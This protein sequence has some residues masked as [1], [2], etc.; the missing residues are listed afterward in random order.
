MSLFC[1]VTLTR[2][3]AK[4]TAHV[5]GQEAEEYPGAADCGD[6]SEEA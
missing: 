6:A 3:A 5:P 2:F 4:A 1:A